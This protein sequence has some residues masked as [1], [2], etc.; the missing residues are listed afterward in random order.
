MV[1]YRGLKRIININKGFLN[2]KKTF[3]RNLKSLKQV[4]I[5]VKW[6]KVECTMNGFDSHVSMLPPLVSVL[7]FSLFCFFFSVT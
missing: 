3:K 5:Q 4:D 1:L 6:V 7:Y 2:L